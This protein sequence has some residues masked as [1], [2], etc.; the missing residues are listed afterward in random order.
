MSNLL[1]YSTY[2][3]GANR[4][5]H[6]L[7]GIDL[8]AALKYLIKRSVAIVIFGLCHVDCTYGCTN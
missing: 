4:K 7:H 6:M 2:D 3:I 8:F 5:T 1:T